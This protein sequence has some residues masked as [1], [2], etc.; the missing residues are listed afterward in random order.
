MLNG[1]MTGSSYE[2]YQNDKPSCVFNY[3]HHWLGNAI[4]FTAPEYTSTTAD[5]VIKTMNDS[6]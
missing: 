3:L 5:Y 2:V 6:T 1:D 4:E